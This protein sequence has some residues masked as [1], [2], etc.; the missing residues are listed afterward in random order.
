[1]SWSYGVGWDKLGRIVVIL[2]ELAFQLGDDGS[3][4]RFVVEISTS[5]RLLRKSFYIF[6]GSRGAPSPK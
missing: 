5:R 3:G 6:G 1:M 2:L 4:C